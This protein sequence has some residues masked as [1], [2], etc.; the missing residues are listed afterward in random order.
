VRKQERG[1]EIE[2]ERRRRS[3]KARKTEPATT[4]GMAEEA[5]IASSGDNRACSDGGY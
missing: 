3:S 5:T 2:E 1:G 4:F